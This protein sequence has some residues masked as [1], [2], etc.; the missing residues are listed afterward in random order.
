MMLYVPK[1]RQNQKSAV[2]TFLKGA[3]KVSDFF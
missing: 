2:Y 1:E 3:Y